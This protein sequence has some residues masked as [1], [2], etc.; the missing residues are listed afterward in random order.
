MLEIAQTHAG[1]R[2]ISVLEGGYR[3][4]GLAAAAARHVETLCGA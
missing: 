1:G 4:D 2:L 3:L